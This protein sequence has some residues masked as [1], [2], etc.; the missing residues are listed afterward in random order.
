[1]EASQNAVRPHE[2][3]VNSCCSPHA[4]QSPT[5][6]SG[7]ITGQPFDSRAAAAGHARASRASRRFCTLVSS[8]PCAAATS[9]P[10]ACA[11]SDGHVRLRPPLSL[12]PP[13]LHSTRSRRLLASSV[14][15]APGAAVP[16][17][18]SQTFPAPRATHRA[19][20]EDSCLP[21]P[22]REIPLILFPLLQDMTRCPVAE[23][24]A[25]PISR[26]N[27]HADV[28]P[29]SFKCSCT[30][31]RESPCDTMSNGQMPRSSIPAPRLPAG[32]A[33]NLPQS[34]LAS[35]RGSVFPPPDSWPRHP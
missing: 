24:T 2:T 10:A 9:C 5:S 12:N 23:I 16:R 18:S 26:D 8:A 14:P 33:E 22:S 7:E 32:G 3:I 30:G 29:S 34:L 21:A 19:H 6:S 20:P 35:S 13:P 25:T 27:R 1:V 15:F 28:R 17:G 31:K 4:A 11:P